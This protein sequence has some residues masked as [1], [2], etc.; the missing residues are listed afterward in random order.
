MAKLGEKQVDNLT[1]N[2][3]DNRDS[4]NHF[5]NNMKEKFYEMDRRFNETKTTVDSTIYRV[6][7]NVEKQMAEQKAS[8]DYVV[9]NCKDLVVE[10]MK[11][12][13]KAGEHM[14]KILRTEF[15]DLIEQVNSEL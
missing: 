1:Q 15:M 2:L 3:S 7:A 10:S 5:K 11:G 13:I 12:D 4:I 14:I 9:V 6:K 8:F